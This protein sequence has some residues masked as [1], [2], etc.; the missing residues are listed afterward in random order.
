[1]KIKHILMAACMAL[2]VSVSMTAC[3]KSD[4]A[5]NVATPGKQQMSLYLTDGPG[6][7]DHV[8]IDIKSIKVLVDTS[9]DTRKHDNDDWD[10]HGADENNGNN[11]NKKDSSLIWENLNIKAGVYDI[12]RF[13]NGVD[14]LFA[15]AGITKGSIRLIKVEL[16]TSNSVVKDSV[17][18]PVS[19]PAGS[20]NYV[21]IKLKGHECEEYLPGKTRLW[22]DFDI[23]RSIIVDI[24]N[25]FYLRPVFH[26]YTISTTGSIV[27]RVG[28]KEGYPVVTV[29]NSTDTAYALPDKE[30]NFKLRGLKNGTYSVFVNASNGYAD[31]TISNIVVKAPGETSVGVITLVK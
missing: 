16:G 8:Y 11:N 21:L 14:T 13:R 26:F 4:S 2:A 24:R 1:M 25:Q 23:T 15:S 5:E 30:G 18:Y 28:P 3:K 10:H 9:A 22:L 29:Y 31:K 20:A 17:T 27:G 19:L 12:L 6:L 7:F